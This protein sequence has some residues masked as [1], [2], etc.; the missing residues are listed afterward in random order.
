MH[1]DF[2]QVCVTLVVCFKTT[3]ALKVGL[4]NIW[5]YSGSPPKENSLRLWGPA[6]V[7]YMRNTSE[8]LDIRQLL[9]CLITLANVIWDSKDFHP[10]E[11][12]CSLMVPPPPPLP[13]PPHTHTLYAP[14]FLRIAGPDNSSTPT[15]HHLDTAETIFGKWGRERRPWLNGLMVRDTAV[16]SGRNQ[17]ALCR[18]YDLTSCCKGAEQG[19]LR[20][21]LLKLRSLS[22]APTT[23]SGGPWCNTEITAW[24]IICRNRIICDT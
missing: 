13:Q 15:C 4:T 21:L 8:Q 3:D 6:I 10:F 17:W 19:N 16:S 20:L 14:S 22:E 18:H 5:S 1:D 23:P 24:K 11:C 7:K 2:H 12:I 9:F